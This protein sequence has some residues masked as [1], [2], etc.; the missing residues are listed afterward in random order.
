MNGLTLLK[1]ALMSAWTLCWTVNVAMAQGGTPGSGS[2]E[3]A[4]AARVKTAPGVSPDSRGAKRRKPEPTNEMD[5]TRSAISDRPD[6]ASTEREP[7][8]GY[9][10]HSVR[11][12]L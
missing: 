2:L 7:T 5:A 6:V 11:I 9:S 8:A 12:R 10:P 4:A 3:P 1:L